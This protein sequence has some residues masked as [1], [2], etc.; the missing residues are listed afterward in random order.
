MGGWEGLT[1]AGLFLVVDEV[2]E[3]RE[4]VLAGAVGAKSVESGGD[5]W[6][7]G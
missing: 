2:G 1:F 4:V 7:G 5:G 3:R 6:V